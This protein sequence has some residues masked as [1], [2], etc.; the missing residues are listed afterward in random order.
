MPKREAPRRAINDVMADH[1]QEL[2]ARDGV[3]GVAIGETADGNPCILILLREL[4]EAHRL[5][6]PDQLEGHPVC[7]FES[8]EIRPLGRQDE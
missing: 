7:L 6:L 1:V 8:G 5:A 2:M 3:T 4:T